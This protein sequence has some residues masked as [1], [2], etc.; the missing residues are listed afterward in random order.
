MGI[1]VTDNIGILKLY[2]IQVAKQKI[3]KVILI[4]SDSLLFNFKSKVI[5]YIKKCW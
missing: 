4:V 1:Y 2:V 3:K 5:S